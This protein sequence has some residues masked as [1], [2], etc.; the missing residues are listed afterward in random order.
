[1]EFKEF[2]EKME[3]AFANSDNVEVDIYNDQFKI[4]FD[5]SVN[6]TPEITI[7]DDVAIIDFEEGA[8][9]F[10]S[11]ATLNIEIHDYYMT[12]IVGSEKIKTEI[13]TGLIEGR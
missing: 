1:M 13:N 10:S 4:W 5:A 3:Y 11:S 9:E 7:R 12:F 6:G 2:C 8:F